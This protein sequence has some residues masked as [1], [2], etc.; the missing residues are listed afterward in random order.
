VASAPKLPLTVDEKDHGILRGTI[1]GGVGRLHVDTGSG[2]V[3]VLAG[4]TATT[5]TRVR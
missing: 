4:A 3:S 1:G 5:R 2:G